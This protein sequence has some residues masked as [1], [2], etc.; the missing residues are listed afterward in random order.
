MSLIRE[1]KEGA[2][3][4]IAPSER[5]QIL[6]V[7]EVRSKK[8]VRVRLENAAECPYCDSTLDAEGRC[9][10]PKCETPDT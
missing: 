2:G 4:V 10:N 7:D 3:I 9:K 8:K 1:V 6:F 5:T